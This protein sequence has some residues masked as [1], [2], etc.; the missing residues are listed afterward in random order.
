MGKRYIRHFRKRSLIV[1]EVSDTDLSREE[2]AFLN[3]MTEAVVA[4]YFDSDRQSI[5]A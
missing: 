3:A 4:H 1:S 5:A 2:V